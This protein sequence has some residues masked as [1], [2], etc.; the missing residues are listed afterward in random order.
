M[1][2]VRL[3]YQD[4]FE[5]NDWQNRDF[6]SYLY[7]YE[8]LI[9][10]AFAMFCVIAVPVFIFNCIFECDYMYTYDQS[11]LSIFSFILDRLPHRI[12]WTLI[13]VAGYFGLTVIFTY[14][15]HRG[16]VG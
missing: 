11:A 14:L 1:E 6:A 15:S 9:F 12:F 4:F 3:K 10:F 13:A 7:H 16:R 5:G 2:K 8:Y